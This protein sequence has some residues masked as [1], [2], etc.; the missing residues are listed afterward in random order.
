MKL[1]LLTSNISIPEMKY[2][3]IYQQ[4]ALSWE[5]L[6]TAEENPLQVFA[7]PYVLFNYPLQLSSY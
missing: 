5:K 2:S 3:T 4:P 1:I 7:T 6:G